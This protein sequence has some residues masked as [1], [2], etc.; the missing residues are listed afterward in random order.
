GLEDS[1]GLDSFLA[2]FLLK[3]GFSVVDINPI[4]T[5]RGR[6]LTVHRDKSDNRDAVLIAKTLIREKVSL[7]P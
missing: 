7:H 2:E 5:D 4:S 1:Q 6:R 3:K